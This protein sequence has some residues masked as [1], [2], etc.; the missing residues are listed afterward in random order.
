ML[1]EP[2]IVVGNLVGN[3]AV[4]N[5]KSEAIMGKKGK[6][7]SSDLARIQKANTPKNGGKTSKDSY[8]ARIQRTVDKEKSKKPK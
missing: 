7:T 4:A 5:K 2:R 6:P 1:Y 8:V 3:F